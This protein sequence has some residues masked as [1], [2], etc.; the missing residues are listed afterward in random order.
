MVEPP[1]IGFTGVVWQARPTEQLA[2]DLT[3][4]PGAAPMADAST[5]WAKL[6]A[7]FGAAVVEYDQIVAKIRESW[8]SGE[9][10]AVLER[11]TKLRDW[12]VDAAAAAGQNAAKA[13][14]QAVAHEVARLAMPHVVEIAALEAAKRGI[15]QAGAALGAPLVAAAAQVDSEQD[16]AKAN[17]ARVMQS[18]EAAATPLATPWEQQHPPVIASAAALEA[19][20][21]GNQATTAAV[22]AAGFPRIGGMPNRVGLSMPRAKTAY[23]AQTVS[24]SVAAPEVVP[25]EPTPVVTDNAA[26][27]MVPG[28][29][30]PGMAA[31]D[32]ERAAR[33]GAPAAPRP[34]EGLQIETGVEAAPP[35][36]GAA[37]E[38][39]ARPESAHT[40]AAP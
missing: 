7:S 27:R 39:A 22:A 4:G 17:A 5:A 34:G 28:A 12:L 24:Q 9:S 30:A 2:R 21:G 37:P 36:L 10:E 33:A 19:E 13:G 14:A 23:H 15:E 20:A 29:M 6:A 40:E 35:V 8:R 16:L 11:I 38:Q 32:T 25:V 1:V 31:G 18:Y 3:T 26:S